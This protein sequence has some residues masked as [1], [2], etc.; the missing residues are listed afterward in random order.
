MASL[1][2][3]FESLSKAPEQVRDENL[4]KWTRSIE[5]TSP[6]SEVEPRSRFKTAGVIQN[7]RIDPGRGGG[8]VDATIIDGTGQMV[9]RWLGRSRLSGIRLGMGLIVEGIAAAGEGDECV[10]LNPEY[11]LVSGPEHG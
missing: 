11:Q 4:R 2:G 9:V 3:L 5:G 10:I 8:S 7:L 1:S 6:I